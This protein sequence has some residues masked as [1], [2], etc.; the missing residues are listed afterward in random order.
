MTRI[1]NVSSL[2]ALHALQRNQ[3]RLQTSLMRLATGARINSAKDDPA[4]LIASELLRSDIKSTETAIANAQRAQSVSATAEGALGEVSNLLLDLK[5]LV[6]ASANTAGVTSEEQDANQLQIDSILTTITRIGSTTSFGGMRLFTPE[7]GY[8]PEGLNSTALDQLK[9]NNVQFSRTPLQ[10]NVNVLASAQKAELQLLTAKSTVAGPT[11][12]L[13]QGAKGATQLAF[14]S[15]VSMSEMVAGIQRASDSTG[16]TAV[17]SSDNKS[18]RLLSLDYGASSFVSVTSTNTALSPTAVGGLNANTTRGQDAAITV[19][20]TAMTTDGLKAHLVS[21]ALDMSFTLSEDNNEAG[22]KIAFAINGGGAAFAITPDVSDSTMVSLNLGPID[23]NRLGGIRDLKVN[24]ALSDLA[25]GGKAVKN[26]QLSDRIVNQAISDVSSW[27]AGIGA[28]ENYT[29]G[30]TI[31]ALS[32]KLENLSS[33]Y[34]AIH[35]TDYAA[36]TAE[37]TRAQILVQSST[38]ALTMANQS[39]NIILKLLGD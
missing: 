37:M 32:V 19:N 4:G 33:A 8:E 14:A 3:D 6:A 7:L 35:D 17:L 25:T 38:W 24:Y 10:V 30:S 13:I 20:G 22:Q 9:I 36:E 27:R 12:L 23:L 2:I 15:G 31:N 1:G 39:T 5:G 16:V 34:S 29:L 18:L 26:A 28:F 21:P 11:Q